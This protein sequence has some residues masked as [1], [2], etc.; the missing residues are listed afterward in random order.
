MTFITRHANLPFENIIL[1]SRFVL[2]CRELFWPVENF[3]HRS[4]IYLPVENLLAGRECFFFLFRDNLIGE[5]RG[6]PVSEITVTMTATK[7]F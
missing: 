4:R 7:I 1:I 3:F 6:L 5:C 2:L